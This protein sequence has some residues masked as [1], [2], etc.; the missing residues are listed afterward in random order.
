MGW[1]W[2]WIHGSGG[3]WLWW[4]AHPFGGGVGRVHVQYPAFAPSTSEMAVGFWLFCILLFII[5][6]N[7]LCMII[8]VPYSFLVFCYWRRL[9]LGD[10]VW[11]RVPGSRSWPVSGT[12]GLGIMEIRA[13]NLCF[14]S[15]HRYHKC[16]TGPDTRQWGLGRNRGCVCI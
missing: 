5:C 6:A 11:Y 13:G 14:Q 7:C 8:L 10:F 16:G 2:G 15:S 4:S 9:Y 3:G 12:Q 1:G